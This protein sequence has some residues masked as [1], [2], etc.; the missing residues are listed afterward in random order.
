MEAAGPSRSLLIYQTRRCHYR[1]NPNLD[2]HRRENL[3]SHVCQ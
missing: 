2:I 3:E 1:E